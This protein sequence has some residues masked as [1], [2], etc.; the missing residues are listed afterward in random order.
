MKILGYSERGIINSL[1]FSIGEDKVLMDKFI[2]KISLP[3]PFELG[4]PKRYTILLEQSFSDFGDADLVII[5]HYKEE[6]VEK[7]EDKIV[8]F[9]EGKVN[10]SLSSWNINKHYDNYKNGVKY[11]GYSSN[12]FFQLFFKKQLIDNWTKIEQHIKNDKI[13][14]IK[15]FFRPR[16]IG[17]N[18]IVHKAFN[19]IECSQAYFVGL[20]PTRQVDF[21]KFEGKLDF[22][23]HFLL[24]ET[25]ENFC[26]KN[27]SE[28][29]SLEKVIKIF[30]YNDEQI[31]KRDKIT[32]EIIKV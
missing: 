17:N 7:P 29:P 9:I 3:K 14:E 31:Y 25:V 24:W 27:K 21:D 16:K 8:L 10:T 15:S 28:Y 32:V 20:I 4:N 2:D 19:L 12:L 18:P 22:D 11:D 5:I 1:I 30:D 26:K 13:G 23:V 6:E